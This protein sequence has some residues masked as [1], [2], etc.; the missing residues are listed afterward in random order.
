ML[1]TGII[2][3]AYFDCNSY[4]VGFKALHDDGYDCCDYHGFVSSD[5]PLYS[6]S[7][8]QLESYLK[9]VRRCA[10]YNAILIWQLHTIWPLPC[11]DKADI[12]T[13]MCLVKRS[14][15]GAHLIDC[16]RVV[17]HPMLPYGNGKD[18]N[19]T[20]TFH[21]NQKFFKEL[22]SFAQEYGV[23]ICI[24]NL[25]YLQ[26]DICRVDK[27]LELVDAVNEE[28]CKMCLDVGHSHLFHE[29]IYATVLK[30]GSR[31]SALHIHDNRGDVDSHLIPWMGTI[32]W[33]A[34]SRALKQI[35]FNGCISL[36]TQI[37]DNV[38]QPI[39]HKLALILS[40]IAKRIADI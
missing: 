39:R 32:D 31:L 20:Q 23:T 25:P 36:E 5:S 30:I 24:E 1:K 37:N 13:S 33:N 29:D 4:Q 26:S 15:V 27:V 28:N 35:G 38:P 22:S 19:P 16:Q 9:E 34:L 17:V 6:C 8:Q 2:S 12:E 14:I 3:S 40:E 21:L 11:G 18:E 10:E 7:M